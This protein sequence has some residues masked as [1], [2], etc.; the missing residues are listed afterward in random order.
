MVKD[1]D[2][3]SQ[4]NQ[5]WVVCALHNTRDCWRTGR[6]ALGL[7]ELDHG[8]GLKVDEA[9]GCVLVVWVVTHWMALV[10]EGN[11]TDQRG[12]FR[13]AEELAENGS[14]VLTCLVK[15]WIRGIVKVVNCVWCK[16]V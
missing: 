10:T 4:K 3:V 8:E 16:C 2:I 12:L 5:V 13:A 1:R 6:T 14:H 15:K 7:E 11:G 9:S